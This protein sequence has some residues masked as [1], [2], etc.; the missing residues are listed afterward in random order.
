MVLVFWFVGLIFVGLAIPLIKRKVR[1]N[2]LYG[3]RVAATLE[4]E[5]VW[6][7]ANAHSG[8]DLLWLGIGTIIISSALFALPWRDQGSY[9]LVCCVILVVGVVI[10]AIRG[11]RIAKAVSREV[12]EQK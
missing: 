4:N 1:P 5:K 7:E 9:A 11:L 12:D 2:A 3:L 6:Y 10:Y 8:R